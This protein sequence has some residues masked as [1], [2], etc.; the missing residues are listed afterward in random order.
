MNPL[1]S[2]SAR[3]ACGLAAALALLTACESMSER[4]RGTAIGAGGG[5]V[6]GAAIGSATGHS[7]GKGAVIGGAI[8]AVAGN[9]WSKRMEDKRKEMQAAT[10]GSGVDVER[11]QDNQLKVSVPN[12]ISFDTGRADIKP[13]MRPVLDQLT[14]GLD[15]KVQVTVVGHT[16][17][18]GS[19][20]INDAL[21]VERAQAVRNY[22][23]V[24][25]VDAQRINVQ[26]RGSREPVA[27][28]AND[29]GRAQ[30]RRV[31]IFLAEQSA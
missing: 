6:A 8:G 27:S 7:A 24:R 16:D 14:K 3:T 18:T 9:L 31:E 21:S 10:A 19:D 1:V 23:S 17:S 2:R 20:A 4:Q 28:N 5:T 30:N 13:E 22:L 11:T 15:P 12:D 26:G 29:S 25:G